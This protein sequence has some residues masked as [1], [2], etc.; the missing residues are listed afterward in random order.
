MR[1]NT[2]ETVPLR[3][4][5][6][7]TETAPQLVPIGDVV[8]IKLGC[9]EKMANLQKE[10]RRKIRRMMFLV[11]ILCVCSLCTLMMQMAVLVVEILR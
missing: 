10:S 2:S 7:A 4:R 5:K 8:D 1:G 9:D 11:G 3:R 6:R